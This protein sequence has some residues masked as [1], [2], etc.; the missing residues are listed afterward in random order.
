MICW[1]QALCRRRSE[2]GTLKSGW[3]ADMWALELGQGVESGLPTDIDVR[4]LR[5]MDGRHKLG[6]RSWTRSR[7]CFLE[8]LA[9]KPL[10][11]LPLWKDSLGSGR[12]RG[13]VGREAFKVRR[14]IWAGEK[15]RKT[16]CSCGSGPRLLARALEQWGSPGVGVRIAHKT[17]GSIL[18]GLPRSFDWLL[19]SQQLLGFLQM[20]PFILMCVPSSCCRLESKGGGSRAPLQDTHP[21]GRRVRRQK[22]CCLGRQES[23]VQCVPKVLFPEWSWCPCLNTA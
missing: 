13:D 8:C 16:G 9:M 3:I 21:T 7:R 19:G 1:Y 20:P 22:F 10:R 12:H 17:L 18:G 23:S 4:C 14:K 15:E 6:P 2:A 5:E 11:Y